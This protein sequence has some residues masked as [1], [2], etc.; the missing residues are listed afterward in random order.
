MEIKHSK[1]SNKKNLNL[2]KQIPISEIF[3]SPPDQHSPDITSPPVIDNNQVRPIIRVIPKIILGQK[4]I[5]QPQTKCF[6]I[7]DFL[8]KL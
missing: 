3:V 7:T 1:K 2:N 4:K 8:K 6:M 5:S